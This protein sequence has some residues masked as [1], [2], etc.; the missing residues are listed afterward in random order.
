[1]VKLNLCEE[2]N[3]HWD[4][5]TMD[6]IEITFILNHNKAKDIVILESTENE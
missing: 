2:K 3:I 1:M 6:G 4:F 5:E